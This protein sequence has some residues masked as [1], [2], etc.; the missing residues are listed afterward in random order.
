T[1]F[2]RDSKVSLTMATAC[3]WFSSFPAILLAPA[4]SNQDK[5]LSTRI[6]V[7]KR[8]RP[9]RVGSSGNRHASRGTTESAT[10]RGPSGKQQV[11]VFTTQAAKQAVVGVDDG[12]GQGALALL[13]FQHFLFHGV[14]RD[15][16]IGKD[17]ARLA[18]AMSAVD[19]LRFDRRVPPG[20]E[21]KNV[22][23]G[24]EIESQA[25]GLETN[26]E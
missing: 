11:Q 7:A 12:V 6:K 22:L 25:A 17:V 3:F 16:A 21:E 8:E 10:H 18:D 20:I 4:S 19:R 26:E 23:S 24:S 13:Q 15:Q 9:G 14:A 2:A 5:R 1:R